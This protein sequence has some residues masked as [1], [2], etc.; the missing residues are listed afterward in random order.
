MVPA[1][2]AGLRRFPGWLVLLAG[3]GVAA[4]VLPLAGLLIRTP[5]PDLP[6]LLTDPATGQAVLLSM[7]TATVATVVMLLLGVPFAI[8]LSRP[9]LRGAALLRALVT[10]PLVLPPVVGG[11]ALFAAMGR[12]GVIGRPLYDWTG[13]SMPFTP[14]AVVA[15]QVFVAM[16]FVVL[17]VEGALRQVD[18]RVVDAARTL[19][20]GPWRAVWQ[21]LLPMIRPSLVSGAVLGWA[22]ALGEFGATITFA[23]NFPGTTRTLPLAVYAEL[24]G[25]PDRAIGLAVIMFALTVMVLV[26]V[27]RRWARPW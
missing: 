14:Y 19:G 11:V 2:D 4:L 22:R 13:W 3:V 27:S 9:G 21:I 20:A 25:Q 16:P 7:A 5:W 8:L 10:V 15:A 26:A 23:G 6:G 24:Q 18:T 12:S 1:S 17:T